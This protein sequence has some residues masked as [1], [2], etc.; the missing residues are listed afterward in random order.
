MKKTFTV[1]IVFLTIMAGLY[2]NVKAQSFVHP[3]IP[4]SQDDLN[5][6]KI[7]IGREPWKSN[8]LAMRGDWRSA[9][10]Y[11][12]Q[13]PR[14]VVSRA[15]D[16]NLPQ[17]RNDMVAIHNQAFMWVFTGN[18]QHA[19]KG[20]QILNEWAKYHR[21]FSGDENFLDLGD[22]TH[23][24]VTGADILKHTTPAGLWT[25]EVDKNVKQYLEKVIWPV[26]DVPYPVRGQNQ[27]AIQLKAALAIAAFLDDQTKWNQSVDAFLNDAGGG[28][29]NSLSN[30]QVGDSGRDW[31]HWHGQ[32]DAL[33]WCAEVVYKQGIDSYSYLGNRLLAISELYSK[34]KMGDNSDSYIPH[35][36]TYA[37]YGG[38]AGGADGRTNAF[39]GNIIQGAYGIRKGMETPYTTALANVSG[40]DAFTFLYKKDIDNSTAVSQALPVFQQ[41]ISTHNLTSADIGDVGLMGTSQYTNGVWTLKAAGKDIPVPPLSKPDAF[42]FAFQQVNGDAVIISKITSLDQNGRSGLMFRMGL[43]ENAKYAGIF[44]SGSTDFTFRGAQGWSKTATSWNNVPGGFLTHW[45]PQLPYWFKLERRGD[46]ISGYHSPDGQNWTC[47]GIAAFDGL[48]GPLYVGLTMTSKNTSVLKQTTFEE[49]S[50]S[51]LAPEGAP[52]ITTALNV[53]ATVNTAFNY[54]IGAS[55]NPASYLS[56]ALPAGLSLNSTTGEISGTPSTPGRSLISLSA[57]NATGTG[58]ATLILDVVANTAPDAPANIVLADSSTYQAYISWTASSGANSYTVKRSA[59]PGGPYITVA[60]GIRSTNYLDLNPGSGKNY[61]VVTAFAGNLESAASIEKLIVLPSAIP[62]KPILTTTASSVTLKWNSADGAESYNVKR[63][64]ISGGPYTTIGQG[65]TDTTYTDN[66]VS[67]GTY[68]YYVI[69]SEASGVE[70][71]ASPE[72]LG[73]PGLNKFVW[74]PTPVSNLWSEPQNWEGNLVPTSPA[75]IEFGASSL[76]TINN[77]LTNMEIARITFKSNAPRYVISGNQFDCKDAITNE[78]VEW[79]EFTTPIKLVSMVKM[80]VTNGGITLN[81]NISGT[82]GIIKRGYSFLEFMLG[83]NTY[84]GGTIIYDSNGGWG[85]NGAINI[86]GQGTETGAEEIVSDNEFKIKTIVSGPLGTGKVTMS[87]GALRNIEYSRLYNEIHFTEGTKSYIYNNFQT[88]DIDGKFTGKGIVE[89]DGNH[90]QGGIGLWGDNRE[91]EGAYINVKRSSWTRTRFER[92]RSISKKAK[93]ELRANFSDS[94]RFINTED[95]YR[96]GELSGEGLLRTWT[97]PTFEVGYLNTN[98][99]FSGSTV[100]DINLTKVG[101]GKLSITGQTYFKEIKVNGGKIYVTGSGILDAVSVTVDNGGTFGGNGSGTLPLTINSGGKLAAGDDNVGSFLTKSTV[102]LNQGS[103]LDVEIGGTSADKVTANGVTLNSGAVLNLTTINNPTEREYVIVENT[104]ATPVSGVFTGKAEFDIITLGDGKQYRITYKGGSGNDILL[105]DNN[106]ISNTAPVAPA[107]L[108]GAAL[109]SAKIKLSWSPLSASEYGATYSVERSTTMG[110]PYTQVATGLTSTEFVDSGNGLL[111]QTTYYYRIYAS[112]YFGEG[113]KTAELAVETSALVM[114]AVPANVKGDAGFNQVALSWGSAFEAY[115]Y[116]VMRSVTAGGPYAAVASN[117]TD[118]TYTDATAVNG[119]LYYYVITSSN[120]SFTS[121]ASQ[122]ITVTP[123]ANAWSYYPL[124]EAS[125]TSAADIWNNRNAALMGAG[126]WTS[127]VMGRGLQFN[128]TATSY[129]KLPDGGINTLTDFTIAVWVKLDAHGNWARI[130]DLGRGTNNYMFLTTNTGSAT[131]TVRFA[132][133][134]GSSEKQI[135]TSH[136]L[137]IGK[138]THITVTKSGTNGILYINGARAGGITDLNINPSALGTLNQNYIGKSQYT[139]DAML[140]GTVDDLR[141]YSNGLS[142]SEVGALVTKVAPAA[143][144]NLVASVSPFGV[145]LTWSG[146]ANAKY[147]VKRASV[148]NGPYTVV[149]QDVELTSYTDYSANY[150]AYY[151]VVTA[152]VNNFEGLTSN[153][154]S[155]VLVPAVP[156]KGIALGWNQKV[157]V[158]VKATTGATGYRLFRSETQGG[159]YTQ[160]GETTTF[161]FSDSNNLTN[162]TTYFYVV[163]AYNSAG[164]SGNSEEFTAKPVEKAGFNDWLHSDVGNYGLTGNAGFSGDILT[165]YGA[166]SQIYQTSDGFHYAYKQVTGDV[167]IVAKILSLTNTNASAKAG[168]MI[169]S[170]LTINSPTAVSGI[171]GDGRWEQVYRTASNVNTTHPTFETAVGVPRWVKM[172]RIGNVFKGYMSADGITW[173]ELS[174]GTATISMTSPVYVGVFALSHNV[175]T[176]TKTEYDKVSVATALPAMSDNVIVAVKDQTFEYNV[177]ASNNPYVYTATGLPAGLS[178]NSETGKI[179]GVPTVLGTFNVDLRAQNAMGEASSVLTITVESGTLPV[180]LIDYKVELAEA[181]GVVLKWQVA[182]ENSN[183]FFTVERKR[184]AGEFEKIGKVQS[185]GSG[186]AT[187]NF[188]D[189]APV[190]GTVYYKL[191]QTDADGTE[192]ELGV[193]VINV[194]LQDVENLK[195][196]PQPITGTRFTFTC[197]SDKPNL[198]VQLIDLSGK[199]VYKTQLTASDNHLYEV[200]LNSKLPSGVY[201]LSV[202]GQRKKVIVN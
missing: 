129:M 93:F 146:V 144:A 44:N 137:Q 8:Y 186:M 55:N 134:N 152:T 87:G 82:G 131:G 174:G 184:T 122:E 39:L 155:I 33:A 165:L 194:G 26:V 154:A 92:P 79:Q 23:Y 136:V 121:A 197:I 15:P 51:R 17:W 182:S 78:S 102:T 48:Q 20:I 151:Y 88:F 43:E 107:D 123:S 77:D 99:V 97:N 52:V 148:Q 54:T 40:N 37:C 163:K 68:Y 11:G 109:G 159:P 65:I 49:V 125:G 66:G 61:Y 150:G 132:I 181:E 112:N 30:G 96:F 179:T 200:N 166:G 170:A 71:A 62:S 67:N 185:K 167:S 7:N 202:N 86:K 118:T 101:S 189:K 187:Y 32:V 29:A 31:G 140:R 201:V 149:E 24:F 70:S 100:G 80:N 117:V 105:I 119:T 180:S 162:N 27:G 193:R 116:N 6:L 158:S 83:T 91:F 38:F 89:T 9:T 130:W 22:Y 58:T 36:G 14:E 64:E 135:N 164:E 160:V 110:G 95:F 63:S 34:R 108:Q 106:M 114:P 171:R 84:S 28:L 76:T 111:P 4:F 41:T 53:K 59:V 156:E 147:T 12:L 161:T 188:F 69:T 138:W 196:Y 10:G 75:M 42:H 169:R 35:G 98:S 178:I 128:G 133:K 50:I 103:I 126:N 47:L 81:S 141:I 18:T 56:G 172:T 143:P 195:V 94:H 115:S 177:S 46:K 90:Q 192:K 45:C 191:L 1:L 21:V 73:V 19:K 153:E 168:V 173:Q 5:Q 72:E 25:A 74:S 85:P 183:K 127:G 60:S 124:N 57:L 157:D 16:V 190:S 3:G 176:L 13:G 120:T 198:T 2:S 139:A 175:A 142:S 145:A 199:T 113:A 104:S